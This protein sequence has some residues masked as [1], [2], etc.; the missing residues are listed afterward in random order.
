MLTH[1][2]AVVY[3]AITCI[4]LRLFTVAILYIDLRV[5]AVREGRDGVVDAGGAGWC[6][7]VVRK[8]YLTHRAAAP[9]HP[10]PL[11]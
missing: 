6:W 4:A 2:C 9:P 8:E 3:L 7:L 10:V 5:H 11:L 1:A